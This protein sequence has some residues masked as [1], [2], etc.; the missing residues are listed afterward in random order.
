MRLSIVTTMYRSAPY[1][2]AFHERA[3]AAARGLGVEPEFVYV[4]DGSP[5]GA[6]AEAL[7]LRRR[8]G[9]VRVVDLSRN[10]GHHQAMMAGLAHASGERVFLIDCDLEEAPELLGSFAATMDR[11]GADVVYGVQSARDDSRLNRLLAWA[12]YRVHSWLCDEAIPENLM[13]VRLMSR[14]YVDALLSHPEVDFVISGLWAR[15]GFEQ[16]AVA[17]E[18]RRKP[19]SC[20]TFSRKLT[21]LARLAT[22]VSVKPL[23]VVFAACAALFG[24]CALAAVA[25]LVACLLGGAS[26]GGALLLASVWLVGGATLLCQGVIAAYLAR[27]YLEVKRRPATIVRNVHE[28]LRGTRHEQLPRAG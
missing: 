9:H 6:L 2:A 3:L 26:A 15:A 17:V 11:S 16:V 1:L 22:T 21:L 4:N 14:R 25:A 28:P 27:V 24:L 19:H 18:K 13:T 8:Y 23:F 5:D 20:Y 7:G 12:Y 10:F